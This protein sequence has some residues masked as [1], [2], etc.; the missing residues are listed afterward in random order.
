MRER[1]F[2]GWLVLGAILLLVLNLPEPISRQTKASMREGLSPLQGL[3]ST[4]GRRF[5]RA[6]ASI[7]GIGEL[8]TDHQ[9]MFTELTRLQ[10]LNQEFKHLERENSELREQLQFTQRT[11]LALIPAEVIGRDISGW[12][13][14]IRLGKGAAERVGLNKAVITPYGLVGRTIDVSVRNS[15]VL[16]LSDPS[17][18]VSA[19][20]HRSKATGVLYGQGPSWKGRVICRMDFINKNAAVRVGD[21]ILTSGMGGIFP[22][23]LLIGHVVEVE[24]DASGLFQHADVLPATD[25]SALEVVFVLSEED[26]LETLFNRRSVAQG[27]VP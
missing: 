20:I 6:A 1:G 14:T 19:Q 21:E 7:R 2:V 23:G 9:E 12:W 11:D 24:Q 17:C 10:I 8:A 3:V 5:S 22:A 26:P 4:I 18:K 16:L 15:D 25:L 13:Q 27:E